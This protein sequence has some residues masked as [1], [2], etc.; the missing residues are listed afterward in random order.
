MSS[1][2]LLHF[3]MRRRVG[4]AGLRSVGRFPSHTGLR[5]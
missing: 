3:L 1:D 5:G 2:N 4:D